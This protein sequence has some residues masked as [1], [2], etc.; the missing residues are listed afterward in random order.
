ML[1][2]NLN[3][4]SNCVIKTGVL[5]RRN[6]SAISQDNSKFKH[7]CI[8][9]AF[10]FKDKPL[11]LSTFKNQLKEILGKESNLLIIHFNLININKS[12]N[13]V[14]QQTKDIINNK[15]QQYK[16]E[17]IVELF[18]TAKE[19]EAYRMHADRIIELLTR[20]CQ[21]C[22]IIPD[23]ESLIDLK[24]IEDFMKD[25][26]Q[27]NTV[28]MAHEFNCKKLVDK[29]N[30]YINFTQEDFLDLQKKPTKKKIELDKT[31]DAT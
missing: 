7:I 1:T 14:T 19:R 28:T 2:K 23:G 8:H 10:W 18:T 11:L 13:Y 26:N 16:T 25:Y 22:A 30:Y 5:N 17:N 6:Y 31:N 4:E 20:A 24:S 9:I 15:L 21:N 3:N 27:N 29:N 12:V